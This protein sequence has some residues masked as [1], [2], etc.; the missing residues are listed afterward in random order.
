[1]KSF[2]FFKVVLLALVTLLFLATT[3]KSAYAMPQ[4]G[5]VTVSYY[6][7]GGLHECGKNRPCHGA[8]TA[9]GDRFERNGVSV[10]NKTLPCGTSVRFCYE[11]TCLIARVNDRG[12][13]VKGR[14]FDLSLGA[15]RRLGILEQGVARVRATILD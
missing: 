1:M 8:L 3:S 5:V 11:G 10:A 14:S 2:V 9:C 13:F 7:D 4:E 15:A 12:P 6:G